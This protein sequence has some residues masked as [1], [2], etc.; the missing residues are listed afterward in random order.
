MKLPT[1]AFIDEWVRLRENNEFRGPLSIGENS[2]FGMNVISY[3]IF[4]IGK[5]GCVS[6]DVRFRENTTI[7]DRACVNV[8]NKKTGEYEVELMEEGFRC[9]LNDKKM[10]IKVPM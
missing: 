5:D 9:S 4:T 2:S 8:T 7:G 1:D 10:C 6:N 3:K